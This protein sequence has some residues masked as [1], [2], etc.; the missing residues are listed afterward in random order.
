MLNNCGT[1]DGPGSSGCMTTEV[2]KQNE[3]TIEIVTSL[4]HRILWDLQIMSRWT[5]VNI[6]LA[7]QAKRPLF[8]SIWPTRSH[9]QLI[10]CFHMLPCTTE[11]RDAAFINWCGTSIQMSWKDSPISC[12]DPTMQIH[13]QPRECRAIKYW[14]TIPAFRSPWW[15]FQH[16]PPPKTCLTNARA[17][18]CHIW[19][20]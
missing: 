6:K 7:D 9:K 2:L 14:L 20:G 12:H 1:C 8:V 10:R 13:I 17:I 5:E 4:G 11:P 19:L 3:T 16:L 18:L 15:L